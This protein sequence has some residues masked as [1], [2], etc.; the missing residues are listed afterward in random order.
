MIIWYFLILNFKKTLKI[1]FLNL[2]SFVLFTSQLYI[3]K[4]QLMNMTVVLATPE[5]GP[6]RECNLHPDL[7][8]LKLKMRMTNFYRYDAVIIYIALNLIH[9]TI[10]PIQFWPNFPRLYVSLIQVL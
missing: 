8:M 6:Q 1:V 7:H 5:C 9:I 2:E 4:L 10:K 3:F